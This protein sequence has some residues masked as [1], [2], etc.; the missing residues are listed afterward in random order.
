MATTLSPGLSLPTMAEKIRPGHGHGRA[1]PAASSAA[2]RHKAS[3]AWVGSYT[4][5]EY[6]N[7][8]DCERLLETS[9][10]RNGPERPPRREFASRGPGVQIPSAP[11][12]ELIS[13]TVRPSAGSVQQRSWQWSCLP[14]R[15]SALLVLVLAIGNRARDLPSSRSD[16]VKNLHRHLSALGAMP[17]DRAAHGALGWC[18]HLRWA[19]ATFAR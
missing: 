13:N 12:Q 19:W 9:I 18:P 1:E 17:R 2:S 11:L 14:S 3:P 15:L 6:S 4:A 5:L 16:H 7:V 10:G 8:I